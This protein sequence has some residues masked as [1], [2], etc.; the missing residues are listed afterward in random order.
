MEEHGSHSSGGGFRIPLL[1]KNGDFQMWKLKFNAHAAVKGWG[2]A[3]DQSAM[4][5]LPDVFEELTLIDVTI[6]DNSTGR[7]EKLKKAALRFNGMAVTSHALA[8]DDATHQGMI[9]KSMTV[10]CACGVAHKVTEAS[11]KKHQP[12][13]KMGV[14]G[15]SQELQEITMRAKEDPQESFNQ[16]FVVKNKHARGAA[17]LISVD[18]HMSK[19]IGPLP[20]KCEGA[21]ARVMQAQGDQ[22]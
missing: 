17:S 5:H 16:L 22:N 7:L 1:K 15:L 8:F 13:E 2:S 19:I 12:N 3:L 18:T 4:G 21:V 11:Q 20:E 14:V 10:A 6:G 9:I